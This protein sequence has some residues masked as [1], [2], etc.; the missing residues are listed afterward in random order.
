[1]SKRNQIVVGPL[2]SRGNL[3]RND[4]GHVV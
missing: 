2:W 1:L 3:L 4:S